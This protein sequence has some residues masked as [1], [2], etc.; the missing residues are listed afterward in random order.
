MKRLETTFPIKMQTQSKNLSPKAV[1]E[2][3]LVLQNF[4][5]FG[6]DPL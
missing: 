6:T 2:I 5:A 4:Q 3:V 1:S